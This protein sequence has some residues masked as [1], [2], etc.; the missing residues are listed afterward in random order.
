MTEP[1]PMSE[2]IIE[3]KL[4]LEGLVAQRERYRRLGASVER[5]DRDPCRLTVEFE[6]EVDAAL[7]EETLEIER[8]CCEFFTIDYDS[9][10]R[11]LEASVAEQRLDPA[12]D[13]LRHA[14]RE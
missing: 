7:V 5:I 1:L 12:L 9:Q 14:L 8:E 10:R 3:C 2:P 4:D 11:L 6:A 13:A